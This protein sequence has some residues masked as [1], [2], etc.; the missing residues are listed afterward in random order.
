M[1][2]DRRALIVGISEYNVLPRLLYASDDAIMIETALSDYSAQFAC[3]LLLNNDAS[4]RN[5]RTQFKSLFVDADDDATLLF[6]FAGH[7]Y[8]IDNTTFLVTLDGEEDIESS[9]DFN[10]LIGIVKQNRKP[11]QSCI[12]LLDCCHAGG[13][14]VEDVNIVLNPIQEAVSTV[15]GVA[16]IAATELNT[17]SFENDTIKAGVFTYSL[18]YGLSGEASNKE[19][20]VTVSSL[21][22]YLPR[23]MET[24][25]SRQKPVFKI[26]IVGRSPVIS[27]G[28]EKRE[29]HLAHH[30]SEAKIHEI[31]AIAS[32]Q[33][34][35]LRSNV[36]RDSRI[37]WNS[38][39][40]ETCQA[41]EGLINWRDKLIKSHPSLRTDRS[42]TQYEQDI[43]NLQAKVGYLSTHTTIPN[44]YKSRLGIVT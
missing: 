27:K 44:G 37:W 2:S 36:E 32:T 9:V 20:E 21:H 29:E 28:F 35:M 15:S 3:T 40:K 38:L 31:D 39:H 18:F 42:F 6:F 24:Y 41:L 33:I 22:E 10:R 25:N 19:G 5:I 43:I 30:L 17:N 8:T 12:F 1:R 26:N 13:M 11:N 14:N 7:G 34:K 16:L 4:A 23:V